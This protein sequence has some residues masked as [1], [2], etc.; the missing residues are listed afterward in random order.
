MDTY[1]NTLIRIKNKIPLVASKEYSLFEVGDFLDDCVNI[2]KQS[3]IDSI[4]NIDK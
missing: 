1:N 3:L 2:F 4:T